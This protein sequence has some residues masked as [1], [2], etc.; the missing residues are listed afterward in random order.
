MDMSSLLQMHA[1]L[2]CSAANVRLPV[3][4]PTLVKSNHNT[5]DVHGCSAGLTVYQ[6]MGGKACRCTVRISL[7]AATPSQSTCP[8][9]ELVWALQTTIGPQAF[10][11]HLLND[12]A[13]VDACIT[14]DELQRVWQRAPDDVGAYPLLVVVQPFLQLQANTV[15]APG[16]NVSSPRTRKRPSIAG[17]RLRQSTVDR[18]PANACSAKL[19][20]EE[21]AAVK[22]TPA[23]PGMAFAKGNPSDVP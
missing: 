10:G 18:C 20:H 9:N 5:P 17:E 11:T 8:A 13:A 2:Q 21:K 12:N 7:A 22:Q 4:S 23:Q 16:R 1:T 3:P 15:S 6:A 14:R 19:S